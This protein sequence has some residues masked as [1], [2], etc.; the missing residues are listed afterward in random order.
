MQSSSDC[1]SLHQ[2]PAQLSPTDGTFPQGEMVRFS[3]GR[4]QADPNV[5]WGQLADGPGICWSSL[6]TVL[7]NWNP[8][9][10]YGIMTLCMSYGDPSR[11]QYKSRSSHGQVTGQV[12]PLIDT[13]ILA[14]VI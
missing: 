5:D 13:H 7:I 12:S 8:S 3:M 14:T 2:L 1:R 4:E 10:D 6:S 11:L 9:S